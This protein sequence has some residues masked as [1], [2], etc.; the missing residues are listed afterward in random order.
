[1]FHSVAQFSS[2]ICLACAEA[3]K[4]FS[5]GRSLGS[6]H[7]DDPEITARGMLAG[8]LGLG[9]RDLRIDALV[10]GSAIENVFSTFP[11]GHPLKQVE[12]FH[13]KMM[14][15]RL[16]KQKSRLES[17]PQNSAMS[18]DSR[19][20]L[21]KTMAIAIAPRW[22]R[23]QPDRRELDVPS[24]PHFSGCLGISFF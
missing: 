7:T 11:L 20:R 19:I 13:Q 1:M 23:G 3:L 4:R 2:V 9:G 8:P 22:S 10:V 24:H 5:Q 18:F 17:F 16:T 6:V 15:R 14:R 21:T 12:I